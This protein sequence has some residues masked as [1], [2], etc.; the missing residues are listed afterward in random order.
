MYRRDVAIFR[1]ILEIF[2]KKFGFLEL[3]SAIIPDR[4]LGVQF[5]GIIINNVT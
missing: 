1:S 2:S 5:F 4:F 3:F